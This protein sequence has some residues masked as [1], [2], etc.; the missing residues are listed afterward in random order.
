MYS[1]ACIEIDDADAEKK[2]A[3]NAEV[4]A[5]LKAIESKSG[6]TFDLWKRSKQWSINDFE[7]IYTWIGARFDHWF[8]ESE[9][10]EESQEIVSEYLKKE[11][12]TEDDGAIGLNLKDD[13]LGFVILRKRDGTLSMLPRTLPWRSENMK[14]LISPST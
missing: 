14:S 5:V 13:K 11:V 4:S 8:S 9:V 12:F 3:Y 6:E 2:K 10:S 1:K 7:D